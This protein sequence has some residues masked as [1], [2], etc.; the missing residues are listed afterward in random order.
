MIVSSRLCFLVSLAL[1]SLLGACASSDS[2]GYATTG[3]TAPYTE[4]APL[5]PNAPPGTATPPTEPAP[6]N[7]GPPVNNAPRRSVTNEPKPWDNAGSGASSAKVNYPT[8][9]AISGKPGLVKS[10]YAPYA[11]EVDVKGIPSGTTVK[12]PYTGKIFIVP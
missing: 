4:P 6:T 9:Q 8:G 7:S 1:A 2:G 10:P 5:D 11:G 12:C 3:Q